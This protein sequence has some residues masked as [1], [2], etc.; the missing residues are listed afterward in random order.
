MR[1]RPIRPSLQSGRRGGLCI[2]ALA[3]VP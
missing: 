1:A 3:G 2:A